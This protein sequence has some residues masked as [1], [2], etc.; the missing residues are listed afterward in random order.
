MDSQ[1]RLFVGDRSNNRIQIF[2]QNG[3]FI[4]RVA[5]VQPAER[6]IYI[7]KHDMHL[8]RRLGIGI[9]SAPAHGAWKRGIRIGNARTGKVDDFIPDPDTSAKGTSAAEGVVADA[10]GNIYGAEV[11]PKALRKYAKR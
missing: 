4:D 3:R 7:D 6:R 10:A 9:A 8:R 5:A 2:D 1:G 11:G